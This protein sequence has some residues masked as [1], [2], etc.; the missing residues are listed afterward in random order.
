MSNYTPEQKL[1]ELASRWHAYAAD[2]SYK[3]IVPL[4]SSTKKRYEAMGFTFT[5]ANGRSDTP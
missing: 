3:G 1:Q 2:G 4:T 5:R